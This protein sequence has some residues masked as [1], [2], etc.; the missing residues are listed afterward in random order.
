M[1]GVHSLRARILAAISLPCHLPRQVSPLAVVAILVCRYSSLMLIP[2]CLE[3]VE[4]E[5]E[6]EG[7]EEGE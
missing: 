3:R 4:E 5:E 2:L 7:K 1:R 6:E